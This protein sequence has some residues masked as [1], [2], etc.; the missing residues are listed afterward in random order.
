MNWGS[1]LRINH[2]SV[3]RRA[4][5]SNSSAMGLRREI[6]AT[7]IVEPEDVAL[8]GACSDKGYN[9]RHLDRCHGA[10]AYIPRIRKCITDSVATTESSGRHD[11]DPALGCERQ[12][13][14]EPGN[15]N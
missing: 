12:A 2:R 6:L 3:S 11:V 4:L 8:G 13:P 14:R 1:P 7:P 5:A 15:E 10:I 9:S